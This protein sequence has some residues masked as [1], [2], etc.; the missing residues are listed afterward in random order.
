MSRRSGRQNKWNEM[1]TATV[2]FFFGQYPI[3]AGIKPSD[4]KDMF[5][6]H[7]AVPGSR[8][9]AQQRIRHSGQDFGCSHRHPRSCCPP[10]HAPRP[11]VL[12]R[13]DFQ[14]PATLPTEFSQSLQDVASPGLQVPYASPVLRGNHNPEESRISRND[15]CLLFPIFMTN[16]NRINRMI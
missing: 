8:N 10:P 1:V 7:L 2:S 6:R 15:L 3:R 16:F 12:P 14:S 9:I 5:R 13:L 4:R 11:E